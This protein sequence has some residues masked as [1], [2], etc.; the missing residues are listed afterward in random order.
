MYEI[1]D[2]KHFVKISSET[3]IRKLLE[4]NN[5]FMGEYFFFL[6]ITKKLMRNF[7]YSSKLFNPLKMFISTIT[8]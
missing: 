8:Y 4:K 3:K 7:V 2:H 1:C 6:I 5:Y